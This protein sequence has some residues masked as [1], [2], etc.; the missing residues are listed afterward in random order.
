LLSSSGDKGILF[1][2]ESYPFSFSALHYSQETL[3]NAKHTNEL[4][5]SDNIYL[6]I[7]ASE[8]GIGNASCG[9]EI[10][11]QY[12]VKAEAL[13]FSYS[14]QPIEGKRLVPQLAR[15]KYPIVLTP[16][17]SRD[18][19]GKVIIKASSLYDNI[20]FT[21]DG[22]EPTSKSEKY[23]IPFDFIGSGEIKAKAINKNLESLISSVK[24]NVIK[25]SSPIITPR[26]VYLSD[27]LLV[28]IS[29]IVN[30]AK[31]FYTL[32]GSEPS[33]K[34]NK[35]LK[36]FFVKENCRLKTIAYKDEYLSSDVVTSTYQKVDFNSAIQYKYYVGHWS[37]IPNFLEISPDRT[38]VIK[39]FN[40]DVI[41][42]NNDHYALLMFASIN[43][44][45]DGDYIF[46]VA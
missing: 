38:G 23:I 2:N 37:S 34:S 8:R 9:P 20:Y 26:D 13:S 19:Y 44:K 33:E 25:M 41:E 42:T 24:F 39:Q 36:P 27:S 28:T 11:S 15:E 31:I 45:E 4:K 29:S 6:N 16:I 32:D 40:L 46:Y 18:N 7:Y 10:L 5:H 17:I 14:I 3:A 12:E 22:K 21:T 30:N 35:Y 1:V 43:I